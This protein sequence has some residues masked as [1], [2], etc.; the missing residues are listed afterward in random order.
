[1]TAS[2][3]IPTSA[4]TVCAHNVD[5]SDSHVNDIRAVRVTKDPALIDAF[6]T[7]TLALAATDRPFHNG[8]IEIDLLSRL[9]PDAPDYAR[10]FIGIVFRAAADGST[11]ESFY[12]RPTNAMTDD[13]VRRAHGCQY[14]SYPGYTFAYFRKHGIA[15]Y[16]APMD[17]GLDTWIH[18]KA[19]IRDD[20][21]AFYLGVGSEPVLQVPQLKLGAG[22]QGGVG[23][24]V[25]DG[26]EA[27]ARNLR[28]AF[29]D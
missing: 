13:P 15:D 5:V 2:L 24:Y 8:T 22:A 20:S 21:A 23:V 16:E 19:V 28:I 3:T 18:L 26:T 9:L 29:D 4:E 1:M 7:D 11:F 17:C 27:F 6:D 12:V 14:F 10:G 25:D